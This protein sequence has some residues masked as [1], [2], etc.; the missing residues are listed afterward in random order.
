MKVSAAA[1]RFDK[2]P[3]YDAYTGELLFHAQL[4]LYDD[5]K[6]DSETAQ[7]RILSVG[8]EV[9]IPLRRVV[10]FDGIKFIVGHANADTFMGRTIRLGYTVHEATAL[11]NVQTLAQAAANTPGVSTWA[12][13]A[14]V[15][16][17]AFSEQ[18]S[19]LAPE[20]HIH[21]AA[22]ETVPDASLVT[23]AGDVH[24]V[25]SS[26]TG[27]AGTLVT[28]CDQ[29]PDASIGMG[30]IT[31]G[32]WDPV[33]ETW[34]GAPVAVRVI[35]LRWQSYFQ[36]MNKGAPTFGPDDAQVVLPASANAKP[37]AI[38]VLSDGTWYVAAATLNAGVWL[39]RATRHGP[40]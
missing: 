2:T 13:R 20:H 25:R 6:R 32:Q 34:S 22:N 7:R 18:G 23:F 38:L 33:Q 17:A 37:G 29:M 3:C 19:Q 16:N 24:V 39:C 5:S 31:S 35:R 15:K 12:A 8:P 1:R 26:N 28:L 21:F 30:T 36:Y 4:G 9:E 40:S 27:A 10:T 11:A 14:W